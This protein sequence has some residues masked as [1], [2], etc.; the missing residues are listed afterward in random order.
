MRV[1]KPYHYK[2][3]SETITEVG[4]SK[5]IIIPRHPVITNERQRDKLIKHIESNIRTSLEYKDLIKYLKDNID[6]THCEFFHNIDG[7]KR[8]GM[9]EIH[10]EPFD[11]YTLVAI[12][13]CRHETE[14]D[15]ISVLAI[16]EEVMMLHY[17]GLV[18][19]IPL[20]ITPHELVHKGK[21]AIPLNCVY[22]RFVE[23]VKSYYDYIDEVYVSMLNEKIELTKK[24]TTADSSILKVRYIYTNVD[25]FSLPQIVD[26]E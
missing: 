22:G 3:D 13:L 9:I 10:H 25:G 21:L 16:A 23:F 7:K 14:Y 19:L 11:L 18:G 6:M 20:S 1:P 8:K 15:V 17:K 26:E 12:V 24:L 4:Y 5:P 2:G